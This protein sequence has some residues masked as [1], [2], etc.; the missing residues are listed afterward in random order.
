MK[1]TAIFYPFDMHVHTYTHTHTYIQ[2][3]YTWQ[4]LS[5]IVAAKC[6]Q[7]YFIRSFQRVAV[8]ICSGVGCDIGSCT[9]TETF[10]KFS[11]NVTLRV[12]RHS[13]LD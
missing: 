8:A 2:K 6:Q 5:K 13:S 7:C 10:N 12:K 9:V 1:A 11:T 4:T 3:K